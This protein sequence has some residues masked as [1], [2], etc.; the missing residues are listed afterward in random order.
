MLTALEMFI[1]GTIGTAVLGL[2]SKWFDRKLT[3]R[4]QFRVGPPLL[5]PFYDVMKL[6]GKE[7]LVP[8]GARRTGFL[9]APLLAFASVALAASILWAAL[10]FP[11]MTFV[12]D[13]IVVLYLFTLPSLA[14]IIGGSSSG[15][16][17]GAIGAS[18]E[19]KLLVAYELPLILA[20]VTAL[21][22][23]GLHSFRLAELLAWQ[24]A[25][26]PVAGSVSG[27]LAL[28]IALFCIHAQLGLVPCDEAEA[29]TELM[30][31]V[32][33]EYSG[34]PLALFVLA[35]AMLLSALP[36]LLVVVFW[37]GLGAGPWG[38]PLF[39]GKILV[40]LLFI[41]LVRNTNCRVRIDQAV[42]FFWFILAPLGLFA[43]ALALLGY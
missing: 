31:G 4:L 26:G 36:V 15:N 22:H 42:K 2:F 14:M 43:L 6:L 27:F 24:T 12:G 11:K 23:A 13:L 28:I 1:G 18:R 35:R 10:L 3:A 21:V 37:G 16:P 30:G 9:F 20:I 33:V 7:T 17:Y 29:E 25:H 5:Q 41:V 8:E 39:A 32:F 34:P 40:V 38:V 19:M